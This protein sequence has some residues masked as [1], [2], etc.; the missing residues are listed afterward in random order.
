MMVFISVPMHMSLCLFTAQW[1][2]LGFEVPVILPVT[3]SKLAAIYQCGEL[4]DK[5][6]LC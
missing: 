5:N 4:T 6:I 2:E 1:C 3:Y